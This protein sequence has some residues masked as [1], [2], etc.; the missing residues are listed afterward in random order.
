MIPG[1]MLPKI[2]RDRAQRRP[3]HGELTRCQ[4][5]RPA[6]PGRQ[7]FSFLRNQHGAELRPRCCARLPARYPVRRLGSV[8][9]RLQSARSAWSPS[10]ATA[11][12][13][14]FGGLVDGKLEG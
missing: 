13:N 2:R 1:E 10:A 6:D 11:S 8:R 9:A 4:Q 14:G 12:S 7:P 3:R 5:R